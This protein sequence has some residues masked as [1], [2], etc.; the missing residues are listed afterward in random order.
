MADIKKELDNIIKDTLTKLPAYYLIEELERRGMT[1]TPV[2]P[3]CWR[4][5]SKS[6]SDISY[7][8]KEEQK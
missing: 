7:D 8:F 3:T 6:L 2:C 1:F 4:E 5:F